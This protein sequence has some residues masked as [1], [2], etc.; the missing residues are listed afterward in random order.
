MSGPMVGIAA[1]KVRGTRVPSPTVAATAAMLGFW[2]V[3]NGKARD[4]RTTGSCA[5][6]VALAAACVR[7][8]SLGT[9]S[10]RGALW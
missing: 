3:P 10:P 2:A 6:W 8:T 1:A 7:T 9:L 4:V 5:R